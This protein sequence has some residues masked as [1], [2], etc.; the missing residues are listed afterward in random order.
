MRVLVAEAVSRA[1]S[2][3]RTLA[4]WV[5]EALTSPKRQRIDE[6]YP[7]PLWAVQGEGKGA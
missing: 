1:L 4:R 3:D 2:D 7:R 6:D 5:G